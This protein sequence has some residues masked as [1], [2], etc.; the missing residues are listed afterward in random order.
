MTKHMFLPNVIDTTHAASYVDENIRHGL[1]SL[2]KHYLGVDQLDYDTVTQGRKMHQMTAAE[3]LEYGAGDTLFTSALWNHF[4]TVMEVEQTIDA[5]EKVELD[6]QYLIAH[7]YHH[8]INFSM[9]RMLQIEAEDLEAEKVHQKILDEFLI[10]R[11]WEGTVC[12]VFTEEDLAAP[13]SIKLIYSTILG[14]DLKTMVRTPDKIFKLIASEDDEDARLLAKFLAEGNL[15]QINDWASRRFDGKPQLDLG[16]NK[17]MRVFLYETLGLP[18]RLINKLT[19]T[20]RKNKPELAAAV[21]AFNKIQQGSSRAE[22]LT[23]EQE[24]LLKLKATADEDAINFALKYDADEEIAPIL[25]AVQELKKIGTRKS[26]FYGPYRNLVYWQDGKMHPSIRQSA[27]TTRRFAAAKPNVTQLSKK[28]DGRK[29][30]SCYVPHKKNAVI[31]S[32]DFNGQELRFQAAL[33][34]D[35]AFLACYVGEH[36]LDLHSVT[37]SK[38]AGLTYEEFVAIREGADK[39]Q[40]EAM[41]EIRTRAKP[42]NFGSAYGATAFSVSRELVIFQPEAQA[43]LDAKKA[44]FPGYE[45]Y[46]DKLKASAKRLGYVT[47]PLGARRHVQKDMLNE[48]S[49]IV[50]SAARS[51]GNAPIQSGAAE[52]T[53]IAMGRIWRS[54]VLDKYDCRFYMPV[55][56]EVVFSVAREDVVKVCKIIHDILTMPYF[57]TVPAVSEISIG[58][59]YADLVTIGTEVNE[60]KIERTLSELFEDETAVA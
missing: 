41:D 20:E 25:R 47:T 19:D 1:K 21:W 54:G 18:V 60:A 26:L 35:E 10:K 37:G 50:E 52:Q 57:D 23:P 6:C 46:Q 14:R 28:G 36:L 43:Y 17:Q 56:D 12:P 29:L 31:I 22:P 5:F 38:I 24:E 27:T 2:T 42:V 34:K 30:R 58:L 53:K 33:S 55:H 59:N 3:T 49:W 40:A 39:E 48:Q 4:E 44:A 16:S 45:E 9:K 15:A 7:A 32:M 11:G 13:K 8:G 51:A